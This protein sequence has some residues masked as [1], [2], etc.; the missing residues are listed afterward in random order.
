[1]TRKTQVSETTRALQKYNALSPM[2][3]II[4][5]SEAQLRYANDKNF[6]PVLDDLAK[7][8]VLAHALLKFPFSTI[9]QAETVIR[10]SITPA[11][12][13]DKVLNYAASALAIGDSI[14]FRMAYT[15][16][17]TYGS[18]KEF[19]ALHPILT[20]AP[21][22]QREIA[23]LKR[24]NRTD[25]SMKNPQHSKHYKA[26]ALSS[27]EAIHF[28]QRRKNYAL[29][30]TNVMKETG[31]VFKRVPLPDYGIGRGYIKEVSRER[32]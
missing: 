2:M 1:M 10:R 26:W 19:R 21:T 30:I 31:V 32:S 15:Y 6:M 16:G 8:D 29:A 17:E 25:F 3:K 24:I 5:S 28:D 12:R 20:D 14:V 27:P 22:L 7:A 4:F 23:F 13:K 18:M 9:A 11:V